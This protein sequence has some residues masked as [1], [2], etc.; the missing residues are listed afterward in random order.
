MRPP[1]FAFYPADFAN[2]L[3]VEAMSTLQVGAYMLLLCKA[4]QGEPPA[5]LPT[6]DQVLARYA[7]VDAGVW[8]E[9]KAGVLAPFHVG[10]DGRL[11]S[12]RL[13]REYDAAL[14]RMRAA[15][16]AGSAGGRV[17]QRAVKAA[18]AANSQA[19]LEGSLEPPLKGR[20]SSARALETGD[21]RLE[22]GEGKDRQTP[23]P[24]ATGGESSVGP[25][26][27]PFDPLRSAQEA[28][29]LFESRWAAAGLRRFSRLSPS[30]QGRLAALLLDPWWA[31]HYPLALARAGGIPFLAAGA[32]R[33]KGAMDVSEFLRDDEECR[34]ILDG[35]YDPRAAAPGPARRPDGKPTV[36]DAIA[37]DRARRAQ[38]K[39]AEGAA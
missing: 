39:P 27:I 3:H 25:D 24:P 9:I 10:A 31:E 33:Q 29:K 28:R 34:K 7:R 12:K 23:P 26:T 37:A 13:R 30:L 14:K 20:S 1:F 16:E 32:G 21:W 6:S 15:K 4:W 18:R 35:F 5:S 22:I 2:D 38:Q 36:A 17:T 11:H 8:A 19:T